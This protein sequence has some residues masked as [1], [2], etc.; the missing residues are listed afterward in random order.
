MRHPASS[1]ISEAYGCKVSNF[2]CNETRWLAHDM[3]AEVML[4]EVTTCAAYLH[5]VSRSMSQGGLKGRGG[6]LLGQVVLLG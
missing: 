5:S 3:Q 1:F 2:I 6:G 4:M